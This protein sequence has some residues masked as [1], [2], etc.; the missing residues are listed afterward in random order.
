MQWLLGALGTIFDTYSLEDNRKAFFL[1]LPL[2]AVVSLLALESLNIT[3]ENV[4]LLLAVLWVSSS[5]QN[6]TVDDLNELR[7]SIFMASLDVSIINEVISRVYW[8][9]ISDIEKKCLVASSFVLS[10]FLSTSIN[11]GNDCVDNAEAI[12]N[13]TPV[14]WF[15][16]RQYLIPCKFN[17]TIGDTE[18][19]EAF[20]AGFNLNPTA[21]YTFQ[22]PLSRTWRGLSFRVKIKVS[23][24]GLLM[25]AL[26]CY[27]L[28]GEQEQSVHVREKFIVTVGTKQIGTFHQMS[29]QF[30]KW[31]DKIVP[32]GTM[33]IEQFKE[34]FDIDNF[35]V[36]LSVAMMQV[37][38]RI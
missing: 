28:L 36:S 16:T 17:L 24:S 13:D 7:E 35:P 9:R 37:Y 6:S 38:V 30:F 19:N 31:H 22:S 34:K 10:R 14:S 8:L 25:G 23:A 11:F 1:A 21:S 5:G 20:V 29:S 3:C 26:M 27:F 33:S 15:N 18:I 4:V 32:R 2:C 12:E